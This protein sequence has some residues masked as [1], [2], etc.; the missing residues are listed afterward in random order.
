MWVYLNISKFFSKLSNYFYKR[1]VRII[2]N[3]QQK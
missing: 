3:E 2:K 1:H